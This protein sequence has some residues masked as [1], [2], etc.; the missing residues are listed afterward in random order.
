[1]RTSVRLWKIIGWAFAAAVA[2]SLSVL[3]LAGCIF[4]FQFT[5][6]AEWQGKIAGVAGTIGGVV[7]AVIGLGC[8]LRR[9]RARSSGTIGH[10]VI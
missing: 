4:G 1:V 3:I 7:G 6:W 10:Y 8:G 5:G 9:E 2:A